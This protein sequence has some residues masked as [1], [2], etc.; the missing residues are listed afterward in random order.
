MRLFTRCRQGFSG[1]HREWCHVRARNRVAIRGLQRVGQRKWGKLPTS[2]LGEKKIVSEGLR[3][4]LRVQDCPQKPPNCKRPLRA[5]EPVEEPVDGVHTGPGTIRQ[6]RVSA[7]SG[8]AGGRYQYRGTIYLLK[9]FLG[10]W[11]LSQLSNWLLILAQVMILKLMSS[12]PASGSW[13]QC[14]AC[15]RFSP[16]LCPSPTCTFSVSQN[17]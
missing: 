6:R 9:L 16:S 4:Q 7:G 8:E 11:V 5:W 14:W 17:K 15:L 10:T 12:S 1:N 3:P 13:K 2:Y